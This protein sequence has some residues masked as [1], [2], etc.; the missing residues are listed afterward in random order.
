[1]CGVLAWRGASSGWG[2]RAFVERASHRVGLNLAWMLNGD[3]IEVVT[4]GS[5]ISLRVR[6]S[7][8]LAL[9]ARCVC[10]VGP[11]RGSCSSRCSSSKHG[12]TFF[13]RTVELLQRGCHLSLRMFSCGI[14]V[15]CTGRASCYA[16]GQVS[17]AA[18]IC[19][20]A[21]HT[22]C[23]GVTGVVCT[24]ISDELVCIFSL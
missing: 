22:G 6:V 5:S 9:H 10:E 20:L 19:L 12:C 13:S 15:F 14:F 16:Y 3:P 24:D 8:G 4:Y 17:T 21:Y 18:E 11:V 1:M 7:A 2:K 23:G